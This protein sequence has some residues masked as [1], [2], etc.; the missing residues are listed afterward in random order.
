MGGQKDTKINGLRRFA[1]LGGI[2]KKLYNLTRCHDKLSLNVFCSLS[3]CLYHLYLKHSC[4][5]YFCVH[6]CIIE[7]LLSQYDS[8]G[9]PDRISQPHVFC[10]SI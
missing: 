9:E 4:P 10:E 3:C 6:S 5:V 1:Y 8:V 7:D 2:N